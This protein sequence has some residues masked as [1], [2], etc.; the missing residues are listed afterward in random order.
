MLWSLSINHYLSYSFSGS[1]KLSSLGT[2]ET[3]IYYAN[4]YIS[5]S[6]STF[7][8]FID[9]KNEIEFKSYW[10]SLDNT[11]TYATGSNIIFR[12]NKNF[13]DSFD[14]SNIIANITNL[15]QVYTNDNPVKLRLFVQKQKTITP[16]RQYKELKSDIFENIYWRIKKA[17]SNDIVIDFDQTYNSNKLSI[18]GSGYSFIIYPNDL[19]INQVYEIEFKIIQNDFQEYIINKGFR[20]KVIE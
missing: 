10:K 9:D 20:F 15:K 12:K 6:D 3:G 8:S 14:D 1:Q 17:Y 5:S 16:S 4:A 18:D 11:L 2:N 13:G 7:L 19:P